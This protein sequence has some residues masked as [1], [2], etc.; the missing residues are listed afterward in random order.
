ENDY[1]SLINDDLRK[2]LKLICEFPQMNKNK[3]QA[4]TSK[5]SNITR[6]SQSLHVYKSIWKHHVSESKSDKTVQK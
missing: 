6:N 2:Q 5:E 4:F 3:K 1:I